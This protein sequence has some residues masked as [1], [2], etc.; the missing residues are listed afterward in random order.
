VRGH[1]TRMLICVTGVAVFASFPVHASGNVEVAGF[2]P[3]DVAD[4][5]FAHADTGAVVAGG[6]A[7][8]FDG[9]GHLRLRIC[10]S[11]GH[12]LTANALLHGFGLVR[13]EQ[14]EYRSTRLVTEHGVAVDR[15]I[16]LLPQD[17]A[18]RY[19][20]RFT[21]YT[22]SLLHVEVTWGGSFGPFVTED[23]E[24]RIAAVPRLVA[25]DNTISG[26]ERGADYRIALL[27]LQ[28]QPAR[29]ALNGPSAH[30]FGSSELPVFMGLRDDRHNPFEESYPGSDAS[31]IAYAYQLDLR[32]GQTLALLT[33]LVRGRNELDPSDGSRLRRP[34]SEQARVKTRARQ[35]ATVPELMGLSSRDLQLI[36]NWTPGL[37]KQTGL[38]P[39]GYAV[40]EG[41]IEG[42]RAA[43]EEGQ[44]T[45]EELV[46]Q[47][48]ARIAAYDRAGPALNSYI[49]VNERA[50][51]QARARDRERAA[52]QVR[53]TLHG[54]PI[55]L[56]DSIDTADLPTTYGSRVFAGVARPSDAFVVQ[57]LRTAGAVILGKLN[58]DEFAWWDFGESGLGGATRN[59]YNPEYRPGG[60]SAGSAVSVAASLAAASLGTDTCE[61]IVGPAAQAN[62]VAMR[63]TIGLIGM[64]GILP[65]YPAS[66]VV[67]PLARSVRDYAEL[68]DV[69]VAPD[70]QSP[71]NG[72]IYVT[73]PAS[74]LGSLHPEQIS[75]AR[76]GVVR[77]AF[78]GFPGQTENAMVVDHA[79]D[80][81]RALGAE[82][83]E[84][85]LPGLQA[86]VERTQAAIDRGKY[87]E[88]LTT[89][90][91]ANPKGPAKSFADIMTFVFKGEVVPHVADMFHLHDHRVTTPDSRAR[92]AAALTEF[93]RYLLDLMQEH[94]LQAFV[95]PTIK[96]RPF[97]FASNR[98]PS[99][100]CRISALSGLPQLTIPA[101][102]IQPDG[103]PVGLTL[104]GAPFSEASL[105][106][107]GLAYE[108]RT[109]HRRAP[110]VTP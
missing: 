3:W 36:V 52:G 15:S 75:H 88:D 85:S 21:N 22:G 77:D 100:N 51:E 97:S 26:P 45:S 71:L 83:V 64:R 84:L 43:L 74:Y 42:M 37:R 46:R 4:A 76:I 31:H 79:L 98:T 89:Y 11:A 29:G 90:L 35:L 10:D 67:G 53:G 109:H 34:G 40:T 92:E 80:D 63:P 99:G 65:I 24:A 18:L 44:V 61:S 7:L 68:L 28:G 17:D 110:S 87:A 5:S 62:L 33:F 8:P 32:A 70:P 6:S 16:T 105:L 12:I 55:A 39:A 56:K 104:L 101:G 58:M 106:S 103:F 96:T 72:G 41:T 66:D 95:Y 81:L 30:V 78:S 48:L 73:R 94:A 102:Y 69:L 57:R 59:A 107:L 60:S 27:A 9:F 20:D 93:R 14:R 19:F 108:A 47:Y 50:L 13:T 86:R 91:S 38:P 25:S 49:S 54:V 1:L 2:E 82:I 23:S